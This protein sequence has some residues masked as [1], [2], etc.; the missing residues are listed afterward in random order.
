MVNSSNVDVHKLG[1]DY[2]A[3]DHMCGWN[4]TNY[5]LQEVDENVHSKT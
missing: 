2:W 4:V 3:S 1:Y 5:S